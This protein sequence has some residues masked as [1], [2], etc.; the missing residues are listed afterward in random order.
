MIYFKWNRDQPE[1]KLF[2][3]NVVRGDDNVWGTD[4]PLH[5]CN[6]QSV[7]ANCL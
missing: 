2:V 3:V 1:I 7:I 6:N 5:I 4:V